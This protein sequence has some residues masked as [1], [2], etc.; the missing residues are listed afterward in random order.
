MQHLIY[1][2]FDK[3]K[4]VNIFDIIK[5][6]ADKMFWGIS[7]ITLTIMDEFHIPE[8]KQYKHYLLNIQWLKCVNAFYPI[9]FYY[10]TVLRLYTRTFYRYWFIDILAKIRWI[11]FGIIRPN[12]LRYLLIILWNDAYFNEIIQN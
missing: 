4:L 12:S 2:I 3:K 11:I 6:P 5:I 9:T 10:F 1:C 8:S 7:S